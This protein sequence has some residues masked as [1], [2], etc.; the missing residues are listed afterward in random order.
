MFVDDAADGSSLFREMRREATK[1]PSLPGRIRALLAR[2]QTPCAKDS[3]QRVEN[4]KCARACMSS[5][6]TARKQ[7]AR[8][9]ASQPILHAPLADDCR[10]DECTYA[11]AHTVSSGEV[12]SMEESGCSSG[13]HDAR[14]RADGSRRPEACPRTHV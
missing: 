9:V 12:P 3:A 6:R 4:S 2:L 13:S 14:S 1:H 5:G 11:H 7:H 8:T 10:C